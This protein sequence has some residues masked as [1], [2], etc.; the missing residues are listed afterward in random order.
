MF[1]SV[2]YRKYRLFSPLGMFTG[3]I[4]SMS[5][6]G[7]ASFVGRVSGVFPL[8]LV[9]IL[10]FIDINF[11]NLIVVFIYQLV[12]IHFYYAYVLSLLFV[13]SNWVLQLFVMPSRYPL[14]L[15]FY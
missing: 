4:W 14:R 3:I 13:S 5:V 12:W 7:V 6:T 15:V 2:L 1:W 9:I 10:L 8:C 11:F